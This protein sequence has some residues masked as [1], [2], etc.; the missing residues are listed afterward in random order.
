[1][2][3]V[4]QRS[5]RVLAVTT[6]S[7]SSALLDGGRKEIRGVRSTGGSL[8]VTREGTSPGRPADSSTERLGIGFLCGFGLPPVEFV[9]LTADLGCSHM[10]TV[11]HGL[12]LL[13]LGY[14]P[15]S[16]KDDSLRRDVLAAMDHRGV[17]ISLGDGFL[18]LPAAD[19]LNFTQDL[20]ALAALGVPR[21][22][23]VSLD[24]TWA[25]PSTSSR[26]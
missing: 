8:G 15:Y 12:P 26:C 4:R 9:H 7:A 11:V 20:D 10:S 19:M 13:P 16:L 24:P 22:N 25:A 3:V 21:I 5:G 6:V 14:P 18:V 17:T 23:A 2:F 1:M